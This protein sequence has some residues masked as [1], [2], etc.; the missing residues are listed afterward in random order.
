MREDDSMPT[1]TNPTTETTELASFAL[2]SQNDETL[3]LELIPV[4]VL[5]HDV[6]GTPSTFTVERGGETLATFGV[7]E[8]GQA[9]AFGADHAG[10][11]HVITEAA[12]V[13]S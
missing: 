7:G 4:K 8:I 2:W 3:G 11:L 5:A 12:A 9:L 10:W 1:E 13:A 6:P